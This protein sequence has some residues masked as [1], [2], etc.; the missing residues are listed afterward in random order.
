MPDFLS[1]LDTPGSSHP[2][3][4]IQ[5]ISAAVTGC[6]LFSG[7]VGLIYEVLWIRMLGLVFG[8]TVFALTTVLAAFMGGLALG[9]FAFGRVADSCRRVLT[10]YGLLEIGIGAYCFFLPILLPW[11]STLY[12]W[13]S[14]TWSPS[15]TS[16]SFIQ[17]LLIAALL[18]PPTALMGA[19]LPVLTR[20]FVREDRHLGRQV[21][22][23]YAINTLGAALGALVGGYWLVPTLGISTTLRL[24]V[25]LNIGI[26]IEE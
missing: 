17:F 16:F 13:I 25:V 11:I 22:M 24:A 26:G 14:R 8:H 19:T 3:R 2:R 12:L 9:S 21:G 23:L 10:L 18:V 15:Y 5:Q 1:N 7:V 4:E 20:F 6:F